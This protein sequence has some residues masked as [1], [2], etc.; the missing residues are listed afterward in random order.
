[1]SFLKEIK[2]FLGFDPDAKR[3][4]IGFL[5]TTLFSSTIKIPGDI[6]PLDRWEMFADPLQQV[7]EKENLGMITDGGSLSVPD[8]D[9]DYEGEFSAIDV[10]LYDAIKG[11]PLLREELARLQAPSGTVLLYEIDGKEWE[12]PVYRLQN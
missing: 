6:D 10:H 5:R 7:L 9:G 2:T 4:S 1:M 8:E 11:L 12:E 3:K